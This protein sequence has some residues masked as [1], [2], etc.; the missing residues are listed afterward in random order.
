M[1]TLKTC[2]SIIIISLIVV[3][4]ETT[5]DEDY[6]DYIKLSDEAVIDTSGIYY[7]GYSLQTTFPRD[8][9]I[10]TYGYMTAKVEDELIIFSFASQQEIRRNPFYFI[11]GDQAFCVNGEISVH[12]S[13]HIE[14]LDLG[15]YI[16]YDND[17]IL[18]VELYSS[19]YNYFDPENLVET[20]YEYTLYKS[21][22]RST[23]PN[24]P[25]N[26]VGR[27]EITYKDESRIKGS[28]HAIAVSL[29]NNK[30]IK[31]ENGSFDC[32]RIFPYLLN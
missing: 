7:D 13:L 14:K 11:S 19:G 2:I 31:V 4:C 15:E 29:E 28:F 30:T 5:N 9:S 3:A 22:Y 24:G 12:I 21:N 18:N 8:T 32:A 23:V 10:S 27:I 25:S 17:T 26:E 20:P 16:L 6:L 1:K